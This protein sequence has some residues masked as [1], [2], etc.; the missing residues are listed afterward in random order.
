MT[1]QDNRIKLVVF[2]N[3]TLGYIFP[4]MPN[5]ISILHE[6]LLRGAPHTT[7]A[8]PDSKHINA[9]D[10]VKLAS[11][12]DFNDFNVHFGSFGNKEEYIFQD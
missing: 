10:S 6:S 9:T 7:N 4:S 5:S 12:K 1:M 2:N 3:H 11:E 8:F